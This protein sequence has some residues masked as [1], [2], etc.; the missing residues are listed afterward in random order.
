M[1]ALLAI[2]IPYVLTAH[3][4]SRS[5]VTNSTTDSNASRNHDYFSYPEMT[6]VT[7]AEPTHNGSTASV[8][9]VKRHNQEGIWVER[10]LNVVIEDDGRVV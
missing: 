3:V 9:I 4:F 5:R 2:P 10:G 8:G 7:T 1:S 6:S